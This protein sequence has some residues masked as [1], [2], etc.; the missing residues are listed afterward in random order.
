MTAPKKG[1]NRN[2]S[3]VMTVPTEMKARTDEKIFPAGSLTRRLLGGPCPVAMK[4]V[5]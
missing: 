3:A 5:K 2:N 4:L 1:P